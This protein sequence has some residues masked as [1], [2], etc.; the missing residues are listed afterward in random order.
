MLAG[1]ALPGTTFLRAPTPGVNGAASGLKSILPVL[2]VWA[3]PLTPP[4]TATDCVLPNPLPPG[5][6]GAALG[7]NPLVD[8]EAAAPAA[9]VA[10]DKSPPPTRLGIWVG[11]EEKGGALRDVGE[12]VGGLGEVGEK[13]VLRR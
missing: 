8:E 7:L 9:A 3:G 1:T 6:N 13:G 2:L 12:N 5:I 4:G 11:C 10:E